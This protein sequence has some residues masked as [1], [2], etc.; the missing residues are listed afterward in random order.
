MTNQLPESTTDTTLQETSEAPTFE[1]QIPVSQNILYLSQ[2][3]TG[4]AYVEEFIL[5]CLSMIVKVG[6]ITLALIYIATLV[7]KSFQREWQSP[8][9]IYIYQDSATCKNSQLHTSQKNSFK[10]WLLPKE[11]KFT[12]PT[13]R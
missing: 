8:Q 6:L 1:E 3:T 5:S 10:P 7:W 11:P 9:P 13:K 12:Q 4:V 2:L